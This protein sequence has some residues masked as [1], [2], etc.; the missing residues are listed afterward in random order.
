MDISQILYLILVFLSAPLLF[1]VA[2]YLYDKY[3]QNQ[4]VQSLY[5]S[6]AF[7]IFGI[8]V[9]LLI[10]EQ[11][12]LN[13]AYPNQ[14]A[15]SPGSLPE[16]VA[17]IL[18]CTAIFMVA[19]GLWFLN[20]FSLSFLPENYAKYIYIIGPFAFI[21]AILYTIFPYHWYL[22][23]AI[24]EF[25]HDVQ[26][27]QTPVL[28]FFYLIPVWLS[29][30]L[31]L[32]ATYRI[33]HEQQIVIIRSLTISIGILIGAFGYS[34]QVVAPSLISG[35]AFFLMPLI[36]YIGFTMPNWYRNLFGVTS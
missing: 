5:L 26:P 10:L 17:R 3:R 12:V 9:I 15:I 27:W 29:P 14:T 31:L 7:L 28:I 30:L 25:A 32:Y 6:K 24:W 20:E 23:S 22:Q 1:V 11:F 18:V 35:L 16:E 2:Y 36:A 34:V 19:I 33:R 21:H 8:G 13:L 4:N